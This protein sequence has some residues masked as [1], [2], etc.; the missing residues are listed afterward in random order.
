M[1][2]PG[3]LFAS[4]L[5]VPAASSSWRHHTDE[6]ADY[7]CATAPLAPGDTVVE[8]GSNDGTLL[9][10]FKK[11]GMS[12]LGVDPAENIA[13]QANAA[14]VP[15]LCRFFA[16]ATADEV[17]S[18]VGQARAVVSTNVLAHVPDPVDMLRGVRRLL[19]PDGLYV[20]E[21]PSLV[22]ILAKTE[23]DT[24]YHEHA[25]YFSLNTTE[26]VLTRAD[27][28]LV[29]VQHQDVHG[30][31]LRTVAAPSLSCRA[32]TSSVRTMKAFETRAGMLEPSRFRCFAEQ[33]RA[34][35]GR[36]RSLV[37]GIRASEKR[38]AAYGAT[39]KGNV[40]LNYC[41]LTASD[42]QYVVDRNP[43]KQGLVTPGTHIPVVST[44]ELHRDPPDVL[45]L[46]A[47]N[48][49]AEIRQQEAWLT[50]RGGRFLVPVPEPRL[51]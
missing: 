41:G 21:S 27:L 50:S 18:L 6:L 31:T 36:L 13:A 11:R 14:G 46:T 35:R 51:D 19:A 34:C 12:V 23:F 16:S 8:I 20:N 49:E 5:Y 44:D 25:S 9:Q 38:I 24:I 33:T 48:L 10:A 32:P 40:L 42:I 3:L 7:V 43:L 26:Q 17:R 15:T 1:V 39:A 4:Y 47:W 2:N 29:D 30:G 45:L 22:D 37:R 28:T